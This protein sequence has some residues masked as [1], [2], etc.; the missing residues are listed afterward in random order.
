MNKRQAVI[1]CVLSLCVLLLGFLLSQRLWFRLDL[2]RGRGNTISP[3]SRNLRNEIPPGDELRITYYISDKLASLHPIPGEIEDLL[4]DYASWS[5]GRIRFIRRDPVKA[6][7]AA[8]L[9]QLGLIPQQ[10]QTVEQDQ[11]SVATVYSG[12]L[13][14][15]LDQAELLPLVFSL[16][17]LEYDISS[18]VRAMIR[19]T[20]REIGVLVGD[21]YRQWNTH[22][23]PLAQALS[24][25]G[26]KVRPLDP[27]EEIPSALPVLLVLGGVEDLDNWSL[28]R[29][30][31]YIQNGGRVFFALEGVY[32]D[33]SGNLEA[34]IMEDQGL[35]AMV[36]FYGA[37]IVPELTLE[38]RARAMEY[39]IQ[40][41]NG[42]LQFRI[43]QYPH[44]FGIFRENAS[45]S[46]PV[47]ANFSG[48]DLYWPSHISANPPSGVEGEPLFTSS[49]ESWVLKDNFVTN[50]E[51]IYRMGGDENTGPRTLGM[52]LSGAFPSWFAGTPKPEREGEDLPDPPS[53]SSPSRIIVVSDTDMVTGLLDY[54]RAVH[55]LDFMIRAL[56]WLGND[57]DLIEIR[58]RLGR[59]GRLDKIS[60]AE[61]KSRLMGFA[62]GLNVVFLPLSLIGAGLLFAWRRRKNSGERSNGV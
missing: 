17:T 40:S 62:Q 11:A 29:I 16:E 47:T 38:R 36:S 5:G 15:Y 37:T 14:E 41:P 13:I 43:V 32:V 48:L 39:Q 6:G 49:A 27:G 56:D 1:L 58:G 52:S 12:I 54:T 23:R 60:E 46:H 33:S 2:T 9:E 61:A 25:S 31:Y 10:I 26:Y 57:D 22:Y 30:D 34:R 35:L 55:N 8:E 51:W 53:V 19:G 3:V 28:Y 59:T 4:R 45:S 42:A 20:E 7:L 50:P 24:Q 21:A 44:W 18:R